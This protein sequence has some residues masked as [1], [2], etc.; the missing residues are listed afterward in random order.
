MRA[1]IALKL[2][3]ET[4]L[5]GYQVAIDPALSAQLKRNSGEQMPAV[6]VAKKAAIL[7]EMGAGMIDADDVMAVGDGDWNAAILI[8][9]PEVSRRVADLPMRMAG[10]GKFLAQVRND[11]PFLCELAEQTIKSIR[12]AGVDG[13]LTEASGGRWVNRPLN[14]FTL[15][16]QPRAANL[17]FTLYGNPNSFKHQGFLLQDQNSYS[18]GWVKNSHDVGRLVE[19]VRVAHARRKR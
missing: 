19:F 15:K 18:R 12:S 1:P 8:V 11:A 7:S 2:R 6:I 4:K 16:V 17:H 3:G 13:E 14:T 10:D 5:Q 9:L